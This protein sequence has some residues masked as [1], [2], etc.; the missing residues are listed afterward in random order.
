MLTGLEI[1]AILLLSLIH[2]LFILPSPEGLILEGQLSTQTVLS[3]CLSKSKKALLFKNKHLIFLALLQ[4]QPSETN[5]LFSAL[6]SSS[7]SV[8]DSSLQNVNDLC[9][10]AEQV[11][12]PPLGTCYSGSQGVVSCTSVCSPCG[13]DGFSVTVTIFE[14]QNSFSALGKGRNVCSSTQVV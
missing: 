7:Q 12:V 13:T 11:P 2:S 5:F 8:L 6:F 3:A 10:A 9:V 4:R 1:S 14:G